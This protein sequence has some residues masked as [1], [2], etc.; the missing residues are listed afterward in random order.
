[1]TATFVADSRLV[2]EVA[3]SPNHGERRPTGRPDMLLLHYTGM[4]EADAA[5]ARLCEQASE[6]SAHYFVFADGRIV[7]LVPETRR[8]WHAGEACWAGDTDVNSRSIGIE[9]ANPG[10]SWGYADFPEAQIAAVIAL[11]RD[12]V[13]RQP[14]PPHRVLGHSDVAPLRKQDPGEKFPWGRLAAAGVGAWVEP[15]PL[16]DAGP[17]LGLGDHGPRVRDLQAELARFGYRIDVTGYYDAAS[18]QVVAAFQRHFRPARVDG[19]ADASTLDTL[20]RLAAARAA[21]A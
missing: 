21:A 15:A 8:A 9:I 3:A 10:H 14:I 5:L 19:T 13:G 18:E 2:D 7:Q 20:A 12:I 1:M 16:A 11:A 17:A 6:V 4:P